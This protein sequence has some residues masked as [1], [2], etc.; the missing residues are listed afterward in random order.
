MN[1]DLLRRLYHKLPRP[2]STNYTARDIGSVFWKELP[3]GAVVYDIG[4][5]GQEELPQTHRTDVRLLSVD[6]DAAV[7]PDIV[8]DAHDLHMIADNSADGVFTSS[9]L[10]HVRDPWKVVAEMERILKPGGYVFISVPF[11][12]PYHAD[13]DDFWRMS[14]RGIDVLCA[15]FDKVVSGFGR[16]PASCWQ[17][18]TIHFLA[19]TFSFKSKLVYG[20]LIDVFKWL[21]FW[22]K[23]LDF[24]LINH[25]QAY[26]IH[27]DVTFVG[28]KKHIQTPAA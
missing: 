10:E 15:R 19:L 27:A 11:M 4:S 13:P 6:I 14:Y 1:L 9:V 12:F 2:P 22:V 26:V 20:V 24:Y 25:P 7:H 23:Y 5:K 18:L 8:A 28:R 16:G 21:L 17:H 3:P